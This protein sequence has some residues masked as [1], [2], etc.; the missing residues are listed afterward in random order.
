MCQNVSPN[1]DI[2]HYTWGYFEG[3]VAASQHESIIRWT[4]MLPKQPPVHIFN[5]AELNEG[6]RKGNRDDELAELYANFGFNVLFMRSAFNNGGYDYKAEQAQDP[7]LDRFAWGQHGDGYHE[8]TRYGELETDEIRKES[9]E[10]VM[11]NW[12]SLFLHLYFLDWC[13]ELTPAAM[14]HL[15][16]VLFSIPDPW[17]FKWFLTSFRT[18]MQKQS[19]KHWS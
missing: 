6:T 11:R 18:S 12:V 17:H 15:I 3:G 19:T 4:Q 1:V 16:C 9:L 2:V 7:P 8:R 5:T 14:L 13:C 10:V